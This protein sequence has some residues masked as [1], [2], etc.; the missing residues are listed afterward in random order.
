MKYRYVLKS[1]NPLR[2]AQ[3]GVYIKEC[4][5]KT[6]FHL[7]KTS[8]SFSDIPS[9]FLV[10]D[11][12]QVSSAPPFSFDLALLEHIFYASIRALR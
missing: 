12:T 2:R 11:N 7:K 6:A 4:Q 8:F 10:T 9:R 3:R 5:E 1:V